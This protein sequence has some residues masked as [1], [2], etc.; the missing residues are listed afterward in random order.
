MELK[1]KERHEIDPQLWKTQ[2]MHKPQYDRAGEKE[3]THKGK[4]INT[5]WRGGAT[6]QINSL[7]HEFPIPVRVLLQL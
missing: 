5:L 7:G 2:S 1:V 4:K 3:Q 6:C